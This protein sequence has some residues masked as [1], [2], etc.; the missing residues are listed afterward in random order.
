MSRPISRTD[1][2]DPVLVKQLQ[3]FLNEE[4]ETYGTFHA[5]F[6]PNTSYQLFRN[7]L[8]GYPMSPA[9][10]AEIASAV[11]VATW[12]AIRRGLKIAWTS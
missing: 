3:E 6:L 1:Q 9:T 2:I 7:A 11:D 12:A 5:K 10:L 8:L 4:H